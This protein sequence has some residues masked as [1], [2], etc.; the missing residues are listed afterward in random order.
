[1]TGTTGNADSQFVV[2]VRNLLTAAVITATRSG[3]T[4]A[5]GCSRTISSMKTLVCLGLPRSATR[6]SGLRANSK[7]ENPIAAATVSRPARINSWLM[8]SNSR[9]LKSP[10]PF[11]MSDNM[12]EPGCRRRCSIASTR[13]SSS[14]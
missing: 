3:A 7:S 8:P 1:M 5:D 12:S 4:G 2:E 14:F 6:R 10:S 11:M 13:Y 9:S